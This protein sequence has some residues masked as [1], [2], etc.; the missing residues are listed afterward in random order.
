[1][2]FI[3]LYLFGIVRWSGDKWHILFYSTIHVS[4]ETYILPYY[5][6]D[7]ASE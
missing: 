4:A 3:R 6:A 7:N 1:M 2:A 5:Y